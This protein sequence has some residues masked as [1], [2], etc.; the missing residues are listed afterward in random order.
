MTSSWQLGPF[1]RHSSP[2]LDAMP[3]LRFRCPVAQREIAWA[4]KDV[5]NPG[6]IVRDGKVCLLFR[7]EDRDGRYAGTS[8]I[9][10]ATSGDGVRFDVHPTPVIYPDNDA[11]QAL[12]WPGGCEDPRLVEAPDGTYVCLY[13]AFN[14]TQGLL[15]VATSKDLVS[16]TKHGPAFT[17]T[18]HAKRWCKSGSIVTSLQNGRLIATKVNGVYW[19]YWGEGTCFAATSDDLIRWTPVEFD[20]SP[21]RYLRFAPNTGSGWWDTVF[22]RGHNALRPLLVPR[23]GRYDS[24]LVEP[25]P[26]AVLAEH[27]IILIYNGHNAPGDA[28]DISLPPN[29]Y[30]P[31]Q[32]Q[33]DANEPGSCIARPVKPLMSPEHEAGTSGQ[34]NIV[35]FAEGL[36]FFNDAWR[37]DYGMAD[38]RVGC[39]VAQQ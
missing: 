24:M 16:W 20:G 6:A 2:V 17:G 37:L 36:V 18:P 35:C 28:G 25:G 21:D 1:T 26:P 27:G 38:S 29:T 8:R 3:E 22:V 23:I 10:L 34:Y 32:V 5:F 7:A 14:G 33:F 11:E 4:A 39:A 12:E 19:M 31:G 9:G 15:C 30:Q 13:T